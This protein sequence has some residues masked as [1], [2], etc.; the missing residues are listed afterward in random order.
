MADD[1]APSDAVAAGK[2]AA[3]RE[4]PVTGNPHPA[5]SDEHR[6]WAEGHASVSRPDDVADDLADFA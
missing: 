6:R 2:L 1:E 3:E 4:E 5:G